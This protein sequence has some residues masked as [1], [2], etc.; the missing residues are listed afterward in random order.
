MGF[1]ACEKAARQLV[2]VSYLPSCYVAK[3]T[4]PRATMKYSTTRLRTRCNMCSGHYHD[5][6]LNLHEDDLECMQVNPYVRN[7]RQSAAPPS[8]CEITLRRHA[9]WGAIL[10][11]VGF[12]FWS[13]APA[14]CASF[15]P[16]RHRAFIGTNSLPQTTTIGQMEKS[17]TFVAARPM[18]GLDRDSRRCWLPWGKYGHCSLT[19]PVQQLSRQQTQ[20][21]N[22]SMDC[23]RPPTISPA[24]GDT[25]PAASSR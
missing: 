12:S 16:A 17:D 14:V 24:A 6:V 8:G 22:R 18:K 9:G 7:L 15:L 3:L 2:L 19:V 21:P 11:A 1:I 4:A 10:T 23:Y 13:E 5:V 20:P 25:Q